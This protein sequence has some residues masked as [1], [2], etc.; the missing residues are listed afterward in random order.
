MTQKQPSAFAPSRT[1]AGKR[2][3]GIFR[4]AKRHPSGCRAAN[5]LKQILFISLLLFTFIGD[6]RAQETIITVHDGTATNE[7]V[8]FFGFYAD[9]QQQNQI[10]IRLQ[11]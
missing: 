9:N 4:Q 6:A 10:I 5:L 2:T 1:A 3:T 11:T 8:P 7:Y